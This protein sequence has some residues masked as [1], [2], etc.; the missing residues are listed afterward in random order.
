MK[1]N[2]L[3]IFLVFLS[4]GI[5][6]QL[7]IGT[8][9]PNENAILELSSSTQGIKFPRLTTLQRTSIVLPAKGLTVFD[10][11]I[12]CLMTNFGTASVPSWKC[13]GGLPYKVPSAP[14]NPIPKVGYQQASIAFAAPLLDG[15]SS[16]TSYTVTAS[17]GDL[18]TTG[19]TSPLEVTGLTNGTSYTFTVFATNAVGNSVASEASTAVMPN[20]G[21]YIASGVYKVFACFNLGASDTTGDPNSPVRGTNGN[22]YQWGRN[23][24]AA[25]V[26]GTED[27]I[28]STWGSQ[29]GNSNNGNWTSSETGGPNNPCPTGFR[30][31]SKTEWDGV[32]NSSL[33]TVTRTGSWNNTPTNF[34]YAI[35]FGT[36]TIKTLTLPAAGFR[37]NTV[38]TLSY[39][40]IYGYYWSSTE[41]VTS[42]KYLS[43]T[44]SIAY[45]WD[46]NRT[47]GYSVRCV[48][49]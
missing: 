25:V 16:I 13:L 44:S 4:N 23:A 34:N 22:Y 24:P 20:C 45:T 31:P 9:S 21:A 11:E 19:A 17:P 37:S 28:V 14:T 7:G 12:N 32:I 35:H 30:V 39:R 43:F 3:V 2:V 41:D 10:T 42:A 36:P 8:T 18:T 40:G 49:E 1:K 26:T 6:A 29:G 38:G 27:A 48:S 5:F 33:N 47:N 46:N 15:G